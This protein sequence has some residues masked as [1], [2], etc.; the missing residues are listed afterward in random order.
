M[1]LFDGICL[2]DLF[3]FVIC[4]VWICCFWC[5]LLFNSVACGS[6]L[7]KCFLLVMTSVLLGFVCLC[8]CVFWLFV[9]LDLMWF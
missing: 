1:D 2:L 9:L 3:W 6:F 5:Y 4:V 7:L 8:C